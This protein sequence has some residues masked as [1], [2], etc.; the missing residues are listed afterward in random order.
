MSNNEDDLRIS[1]VWRDEAGRHWR[2]T[3]VQPDTITVGRCN[4]TYGNFHGA[5]R[6]T[7]PRACFLTDY[8]YV[9]HAAL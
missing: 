4:K 3:E 5:K 9:G 6:I 8:A 7:I 1:S 2:V